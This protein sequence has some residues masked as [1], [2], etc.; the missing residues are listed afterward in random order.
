MRTRTLFPLAL[1]ALAV[2]CE[3][4][5]TEPGGV[6]EPKPAPPNPEQGL[7]PLRAAALALLA[8]TTCTEPGQNPNDPT[9][10]PCDLDGFVVPGDPPCPAYGEVYDPDTDDCQCREGFKPDDNGYCDY[11]WPDPPR[12]GG[13]RTDPLGGGGGG[14]GGGGN[15]NGE[16]EGEELEVELSCTPGTVTR[17]RR[18]SCVATSDNAMGTTSYEWLFKPK[19]GGVRIWD[20]GPPQK[21]SAVQG[22][23]DVGDTWEG[24]MVAGGK[25]S[26]LVLD[27]TRFASTAAMVSVT[28]R[29]GWKVAN[30]GF[31]RGPD[32]TN[33]LL[34]LPAKSRLGANTNM[35]GSRSSDDILEG[36]AAVKAV[37]SGPNKGYGYVEW[38]DYYIER[39]WRIN[40]RLTQ[41][42]PTE[43][44][45]NNDQDTATHWDYLKNVAGGDPTQARYGVE[46]HESYGQNG[47][48]GHQRQ[49]EKKLNTSTCKDAAGIAERV[50]AD[51]WADAAGI[52]DLIREEADK[53]FGFSTWHNYV[54]S[55]YT[56][57]IVVYDPND[58]KP[59]VVHTR[60]DRPDSPLGWT[61][62][63]GCQWDVTTF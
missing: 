9:E 33:L 10:E 4:R 16:G 11:D 32:L 44:R 31:T 41:G 13:P 2:A 3:P 54:H 25:V 36:S 29:N 55:N 43:V 42:G 12:I 24:P 26:V 56:G 61:P 18:V 22:G 8:D 48:T 59:P 5:P 19:D 37:M 52:V 35:S 34:P 39:Q 57:D 1:A 21:L 58:T 17:A 62:R 20:H 45:Y 60:T 53:A 27:S 50:V 23:D 15:G 47:A 38:Q 7:P 14:G 6:A 28:P 49:I 46:A 51:T 40:K 30:W 63:E